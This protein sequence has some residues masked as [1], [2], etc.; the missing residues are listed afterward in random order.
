[1]HELYLGS[2][3]NWLEVGSFVEF[4]VSLA[5]DLCQQQTVHMSLSSC[6]VTSF[7]ALLFLMAV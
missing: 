1:M 2:F 5:L 3:G 4:H 7:C 6:L